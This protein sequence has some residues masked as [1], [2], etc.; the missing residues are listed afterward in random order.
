MK[1]KS[2]DVLVLITFAL[3][4]YSFYVGNANGMRLAIFL[5]IIGRLAWKYFNR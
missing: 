5:N 3:L 4:I 1:I 2:L